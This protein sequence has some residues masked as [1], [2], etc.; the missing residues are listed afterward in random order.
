MNSSPK[1]V[2]VSDLSSSIICRSALTVTCS[3]SSSIICTCSVSVPPMVTRRS[4]WRI[5]LKPGKA[6]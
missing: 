3:E 4:S 6:T 5:E 1:R 2:A